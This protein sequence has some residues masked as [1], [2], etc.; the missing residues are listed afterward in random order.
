MNPI[1][2]LA[3]ESMENSQ[4]LLPYEVDNLVNVTMH[5]AEIGMLSNGRFKG[6]NVVV[7]WHRLK[8]EN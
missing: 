8:K 3:W 6:A 7:Y 1:R 2:C 5:L 4:V